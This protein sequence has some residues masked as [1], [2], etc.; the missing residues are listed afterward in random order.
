MIGLS[1]WCLS[2]FIFINHIDSSSCL[3]P[4]IFCNILTV[5]TGKGFYQYHPNFVLED[6][7][8]SLFS[9]IKTIVT[10]NDGRWTK[11]WKWFCI[12]HL[13]S[14]TLILLPFFFDAK[15]YSQR[16]DFRWEQQSGKCIHSSIIRP[17]S[18]CR[19]WTSFQWKSLL[20][21]GLQQKREWHWSWR[22]NICILPCDP[23]VY[24][25]VITYALH[26]VAHFYSQCVCHLQVTNIICMSIILSCSLFLSKYSA[27]T[28]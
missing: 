6:L 8:A 16:H 3:T 15:V 4:L 19:Y 22:L 1:S 14:C 5:G 25:P 28:V 9:F 10:C 11:G 23:F 17:S 21:K 13:I 20:L 27:V 12:P 18:C 24:A 26:N 2:C 7:S